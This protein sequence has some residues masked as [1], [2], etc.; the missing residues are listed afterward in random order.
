MSCDTIKLRIFIRAGIILCAFF[1]ISTKVMLKDLLVLVK[2][3][4]LIVLVTRYVERV[5][6]FIII[7]VWIPRF[8]SVFEEALTC[9]LI[10]YMLEPV[11]IRQPVAVSLAVVV[12]EV[13]VGWAEVPYIDLSC[14]GKTE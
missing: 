2:C 3:N 14:S 4:T 13:V 7:A 12:S 5:E 8:P 1:T 6:Y 9:L 11:V 10:E